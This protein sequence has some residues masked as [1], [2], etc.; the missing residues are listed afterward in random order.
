[1]DLKEVKIFENTQRCRRHPWE[2]ARLKVVFSLIKK[3]SR[4]TRNNSII[5]DIGCGDVFLLNMISELLPNLK[6]VGVDTKFDKKT[7]NNYLKE[8][9][10]LELYSSLEEM[11]GAINTPVN[12]V[13]M[14]DVLEHVQDDVGMLKNIIQTTVVDANTLFLVTVPA[15]RFLFSSHDKWLG[16]YRRYDVN[17]LSK[18]AEQSGLQV[19]EKGYFFASLL[20]PRMVKVI[21]EKLGIFSVRKNK[22]IG[23][24]KGNNFIDTL[25]EFSLFL[26]YKVAVFMKKVGLKIPGLSCYMI[27]QKQAL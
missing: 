6:F 24:W 15:F 16:H 18:K 17:L 21:F 5:L 2:V 8:S 9:S 12:V 10:N 22:G 14:L 25:V 11:R 3:Y 13:L 4:L 7:I 19:I 20:I 26:D 23:G 27:C 1:M